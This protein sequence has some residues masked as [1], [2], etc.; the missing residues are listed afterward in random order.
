MSRLR[1]AVDARLMFDSPRRGIGKTSI[2]LYTAL[3]KVRPDWRFLLYYRVGRFENPFTQLQNV[4]PQQLELP[5]Y[6]LYGPLE[7]WLNCWDSV[8]LPVELSR[9]RP[10]LFHIPG[11]LYPR[12][13]TG[14]MVTT[15]HDLI[16]IDTRPMDADVK[17]WT[18]DVRRSAIQSR[19]II[20]A[21]EHARERIVERFRVRREK[22]HI[23]KWGP[24]SVQTTPLTAEEEQSFRQKYNL[25]L[26]KNYLLHF[27]LEDPRKNTHR[28]L[29]AW[30]RVSPELRA[31]NPLVIV[32]FQGPG[33]ARTESL[34]NELRIRDSVRLFGYIPEKDGQHL[35]AGAKILCYPS[36]YEGYGLP[37]VEAFHCGVPVLASRHTSI[38]E[39]AGD[40]ACLVDATKVDELA[41][42][43]QKLLSD[44]QLCEELAQLGLKQ[45]Q[46]TTWE[47]CAE[48]VACVFENVTT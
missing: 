32:G 30:A 48:N 35:L 6:R 28:L 17:Q 20:T 38:P 16:P 34:C 26:R 37:L 47:A 43:L 10:D 31:A 11:G 12:F 29:E 27:G 4:I 25:P 24:V 1:I 36:L 22:I 41:L 42:G 7:R 13:A 14:R 33:L 39:V 19:A 8:R 23:M 45:V 9:E 3:A 40:A 5:G 46:S 15:I 18:R 44:P 2:A 21:S